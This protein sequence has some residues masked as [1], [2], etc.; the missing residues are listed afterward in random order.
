MVTSPLSASGITSSFTAS[1][2]PVASDRAWSS[3]E[4]Y[5]SLLPAE[6]LSGMLL[7]SR[8]QSHSPGRGRD[9]TTRTSMT[10][11]SKD[12]TTVTSI[13]VTARSPDC[14]YRRGREMPLTLSCSLLVPPSR[15]G[16]V[17]FEPN[18]RP[19]SSSVTR[20]SLTSDVETKRPCRGAVTPRYRGKYMRLAWIGPVPA[21]NLRGRANLPG[22]RPHL[23]S[24]LISNGDGGPGAVS[25]GVDTCGGG[26]ERP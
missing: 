23:I 8:S 21:F 2:L 14:R 17:R 9:V 22:R 11:S 3:D 4:S 7:T 26:G 19:R 25:Q 1:A 18:S 10:P 24:H 6:S 13:T 5:G 12:G 15:P 16:K 20:T